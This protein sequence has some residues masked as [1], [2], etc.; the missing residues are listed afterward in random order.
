[1]SRLLA[2]LTFLTL[3]LFA[4]PALAAT[5]VQ[6][7]DGTSTSAT[8]TSS[9]TYS[10][11]TVAT[12]TAIDLSA[13]PNPIDIWFTVK[14]VYPNSAP[15]GNVNIYGICS[16]D[17]TNYDTS[18]SAVGYTG[19]QVATFTLP[20]AINW[21]GPVSYVPLQNKTGYK[22]FSARALM[23]GTVCRKFGLAIDNETG[24]TITTYPVVT[25]T[26]VNYTNN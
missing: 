20:T 12:I 16:E 15:T 23:G 7:L 22:T 1:M 24:N 11:G 4:A 13:S 3:L 14:I 19:T 26:A 8:V 9:G 2:L 5:T 25:Y 10:T 17:G 21:T 18:D 6:Q